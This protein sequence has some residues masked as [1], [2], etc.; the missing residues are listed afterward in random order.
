MQI[1]IKT[2][3]DKCEKSR[4]WDSQPY[5]VGNLPAGN[6]L[7]SASI[8]FSGA[9]LTKTLRGLSALNVAN[10]CISTVHAHSKCYL[11]PTIWHQW[12]DKQDDLFEHLR[13]LEG[14]LILGGDGR[15]DSPGHCAKFGSYSMLECRINKVIDVQLVQVSIV[16]LSHRCMLQNCTFFVISDKI[17][18]EGTSR[19]I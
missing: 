10:I 12:L 14:G 8:L 11:F 13:T 3:C 2:Y 9:P 6:L 18:C 1:S 19:S 7:L 5:I 16:K 15:A 17:F 4:R